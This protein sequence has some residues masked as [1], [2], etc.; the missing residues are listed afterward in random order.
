M[1]T[2]IGFDLS[3]FSSIFVQKV[4]IMK[5]GCFFIVVLIGVCLVSCHPDKDRKI[6]GRKCKFECTEASVLFFKNMRAPYYDLEEMEN[7]GLM[8]YRNKKRVKQAIH[9]IFNLAIVHNWR[10]DKVHLIVEPNQPGQTGPLV[11]LAKAGK[12]N[13]DTL[14]FIL[15]RH[16]EQFDF[17]SRIYDEILD[18]KSLYILEGQKAAPFLTTDSE[19]EVFRVTMFDFLRFAEML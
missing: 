6:D 16:D 17:A 12:G 10:Q 4:C 13:V 1:H 15:R 18:G 14:R 7:A 11:V 2:G 8:V 3:I 5:N 9:P 19:R